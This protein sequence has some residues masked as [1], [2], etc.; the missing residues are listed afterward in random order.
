MEHQNDIFAK[1]KQGLP[2]NMLDEEYQPAIRHGSS[3]T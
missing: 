2:V 3:N 1:L